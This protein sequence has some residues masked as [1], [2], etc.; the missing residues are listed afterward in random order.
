MILVAIFSFSFILFLS[1]AS[2]ATSVVLSDQGANVTYAANGSLVNNVNLTV[3]IY[4]N[5]TGGNLIYNETFINAIQNGLWG[6]MLGTNSSNP[7]LLNFSVPYYKVYAIN[8]QFLNFTNQTG[9][10]V[11]RQIFYSP[12]GDIFGNNI[13]TTSNFTYYNLTALGNISASNI[14]AQTIF[15]GGNNFTKAYLYATNGTFLFNGYASNNTWLLNGY[16][17]NSTW[18]L[19]G[20][21]NNGTFLL[22]GNGTYF[23]NNTFM[24]I[25]YANNNTFYLNITNN[26]F[27]INT[28]VAQNTFNVLGTINFT[29]IGN[30]T[31]S[32]DV[33]GN[34][35]GSSYKLLETGSINA[36]G[37][38]GGV[39]SNTTYVTVGMLLNITTQGANNII[40]NAAYNHTLQLNNSGLFWCGGNSQLVNLTAF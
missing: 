6:V 28:T 33:Y 31:N 12:V 4:D 19:N 20:Y 39:S 36:T 30:S 32:F 9:A 13:N 23:T 21:A 16:A 18:L 35:S 1:W 34:N 10:T 5:L 37:T 2:A 8:G 22:T 17:S 25:A 27:G 38:I 3:T 26:L 11:G 40:C 14:T 29:G 24:P 7:L 15:S